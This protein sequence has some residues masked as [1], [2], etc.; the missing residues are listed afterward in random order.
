MVNWNKHYSQG[1]PSIQLLSMSEWVNVGSMN[2]TMLLWNLDL[3]SVLVLISISWDN[4]FNGSSYKY[5]RPF[6]TRKTGTQI[7]S[8]ENDFF[9][10]W[11]HCLLMGLHVY[12]MGFHLRHQNNTISCVFIKLTF[13]ISVSVFKFVQYFSFGLCVLLCQTLV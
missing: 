2:S 3:L 9:R 1:I 6:Q 5:Q 11:P 12:F 4:C 8:L 13:D 7:R 10:K